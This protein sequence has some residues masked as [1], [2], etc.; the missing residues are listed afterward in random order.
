MFTSGGETK[1]LAAGSAGEVCAIAILLGAAYLLYT[2][3]AQWRLMLSSVLGAAFLSL[4]MRYA[5]GMEV[6]PSLLFTIFSGGLL[7]A[8]VYM[9]TD[10]VSAPKLPLS[11]WIYGAFFGAMVVFFRAKSIFA[12][13]VGFALL[14]ANMLAPS[15]DFW[16]K[17]Y[18]ARKGA[19]Q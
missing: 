11:Q 2:K 1:V 4:F 8:S 7:Y 9:V 15:L 10:P 12:G 17:R 3:T 6:V 5:L 13:G 16:I 18:R 14:L 19:A